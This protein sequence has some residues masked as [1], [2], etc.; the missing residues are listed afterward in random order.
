MPGVQPPF[1]TSAGSYPSATSSAAPDPFSTSYAQPMQPP[2]QRPIMSQMDMTPTAMYSQA[3]AA[4]MPQ[5]RSELR[6]TLP[7]SRLTEPPAES[8]TH[9]RSSRL[10]IVIA[11]LLIILLVAVVVLLRWLEAGP[12]AFTLFALI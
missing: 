9:V 11:A 3:P 2:L 8:V 7:G 5:Q 6:A 4:P 12:A 1:P 10:W